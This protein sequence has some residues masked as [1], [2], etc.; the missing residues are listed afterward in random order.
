MRTIRTALALL[1]FSTLAYAQPL[2]TLPERGKSG[3][4]AFS[5][6]PKAM[7]KNPDLCL[8]TFT[9]MTPLG[10]TYPQASP[11]QPIY[12]EVFSG[13]FVQRGDT[14]GSEHTPPAFELQQA[15]TQALAVNGYLPST[16]EHPATLLITF[17]WGSI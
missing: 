13:G 17:N 14:Y 8:S 11:A 7:Q 3:A 1:V 12:F 2:K 16:P 9:E 6:L 10:R 5:L 15:L 4:W